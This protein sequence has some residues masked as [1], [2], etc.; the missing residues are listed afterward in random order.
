MLETLGAD[1][2][3]HAII[4]LVLPTGATG[5]LVAAIAEADVGVPLAVVVL[6]QPEAVRLVDARGGKVPAYAYPEVAARRAVPRR[7]VRGSGVRRRARP[8]P[9]SPTWTRSGRAE[10]VHGF[11][12]GRP[13]AAG[14]RRPT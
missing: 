13:T 11:L 14:C 10:I 12:A 5:D 7:Q 3:V 1:E 2:D 6:N 8:C 9:P 4:A